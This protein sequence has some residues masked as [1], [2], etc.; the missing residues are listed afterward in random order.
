MTLEEY[1]RL[2]EKEMTDTDRRIMELEAQIWEDDR[3]DP[4]WVRR[5]NKEHNAEILRA[6]DRLRGGDAE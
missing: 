1:A 5:Q 2:Q 6:I 3:N 4:A